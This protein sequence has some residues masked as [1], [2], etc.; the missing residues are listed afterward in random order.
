MPHAF[1]PTLFH[2]F[3]HKG[4]WWLPETP[5]EV[6][7][8]VLVYNQ[9]RIHLDL[10]GNLRMEITDD[11]EPAPIILGQLENGKECTLTDNR[12]T[13]VRL[14]GRSSRWS[15]GAIFL[16]K[17][18]AREEEIKFTAWNINF[19]DLE[20]WIAVQPFTSHTRHDGTRFIGQQS[21]YVQPDSLKIPIP[22][23]N[24]TL[25]TAHTLTSSGS[26]FGTH[27]REHTAFLVF[28]PNEA[29]NLIWFQ[30]VLQTCQG[31]LTLFVGKP[32]YAQRVVA[33][34]E[35][36]EWPDGKKSTEEIHIYFN[37]LNRKKRERV[38][39]H[40]M[41]ISLP[42][43]K[44]RI[45]TIVPIWFEKAEALKH[46]YDLFLGTFYG[47]SM[48]LESEFLTLTQA[49]ET[50][51]RSTWPGK[52]LPDDQY[53]PVEEALVTAIPSGIHS[54]LRE[55]LKARLRY[56]NEHS[57]RKRLAALLATMDDE[58]C[59]LFCKNESEWCG[60]IVDTRNY[61]T[62]YGEQSARVI[63][64]TDLFFANRRMSV[65]LTIILF[66]E[67]GLEESF[68]RQIFNGNSHLMR[69]IHSYLSKG[70]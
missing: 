34:G 10:F 25:E 18:F 46:V 70:E 68:I 24:A 19:T 67:L 15:A 6:V 66:K 3:Q 44:D 51:C 21:E 17:H 55:S 31:L 28:T 1:E 30:D 60:R 22:S 5:K 9:S 47:E 13:I 14:D 65:L 63:G 64:G 8:G 42:Q 41:L 59:N 26:W 2:E 38:S 53:K 48:Y 61:L 52:Y 27:V 29:K 12:E 20:E 54:G 32:V 45:G 36:I 58:T 57:L 11:L 23:L 16:G 43:I 39:P 49:L 33:D 62:H 35:Q 56:G 69:L 4:W 7:P 37:Q 40:D 50:Y